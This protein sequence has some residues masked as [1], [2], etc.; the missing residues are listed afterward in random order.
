MSCLITCECGRR[1]RAD[2]EEDVLAAMVRHLE[3]EHPL[4]AGAARED[5]LRALVERDEGP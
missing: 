2:K 5:D 4:V 3:A 1:L